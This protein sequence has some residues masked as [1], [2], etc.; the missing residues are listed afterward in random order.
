LLLSVSSD[1]PSLLFFLGDILSEFLVGNND[2]LAILS[3][4]TGGIDDH[5]GNQIRVDVGSGSPV[6]IITTL[7]LGGVNGDTDG[8]S[9]VSLS[10]REGIDGGSFI[11]S[12][13]SHLVSLTINEDVF[14]M[15]LL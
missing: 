13:Q 6:L 12:G 10:V 14:K 9:S 2:I 4:Q 8:S 1:E 3:V 5:G 15:S 7:L 11:R